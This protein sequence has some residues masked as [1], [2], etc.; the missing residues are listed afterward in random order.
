MSI[1]VR[2]FPIV[3]G[4]ALT[5]INHIEPVVIGDKMKSSGHWIF[6]YIEGSPLLCAEIEERGFIAEVAVWGATYRI[7]VSRT[8]DPSNRANFT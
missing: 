6:L 8:L 3:Q 5:L 7:N 1:V 4:D 2:Q